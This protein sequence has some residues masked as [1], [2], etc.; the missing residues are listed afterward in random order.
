MYR[1][2]FLNGKFKGKRLTI[3]QGSVLIGRDHDCQIDLDDDDEVSRHHA[4][5]E[6]RAGGIVIRDLGATNRLEVNQQPVKEHRLRHGDRIEVGRTMLEFQLPNAGAAP[7][8]R[9]RFSKMQATSIAAITLVILIQVLF[10]VLFPLWQRREAKPVILPDPVLAEATTATEFTGPPPPPPAPSP[11]ELVG[12]LPA[13]ESA[14]SASPGAPQPEPEPVEESAP[15]P[16]VEPEP[17][18]PV[19]AL[20]TEV[21]GL[22]RRIED[23]LAG[24]QGPAPAPEPA[25]PSGPPAMPVDPLLA[26]AR[27][28][29]ADAQR[30]IAATNF[31]GADNILERVTMLAPDFVP[32]LRERALLFEKRGML[33]QAGEQWQAIMRL[34]SGT[35]YYAKAA[36]ERQR[37]AQLEAAKNNINTPIRARESSSSAPAMERRIRIVSVDRERFQANNEFDEMRLVRITLRPRN[38]EGAV[39]SDQVQVVVTFFD[40]V[41]GSERL[42]RTRALVPEEPIRLEGPW[43]AGE[44]RNITAAYMLKNGFRDEEFRLLGEK[45]VYEGHV[46]AVYYRGVLQD[47]S[48]LPQRLLVIEPP[49]RALAR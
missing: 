16:S 39:A 19:S 48:A 40:R 27:E 8:Q 25:V 20:R 4:V 44:S 26:K 14:S 22:R 15:A 12:P 35:P 42:V 2:L 47:A 18:S 13:T 5:I 3:Q 23:Q 37:I 6:Y 24:E 9:R 30:E 21:E 49:P 28:M 11:S 34:S 33:K 10:V 38:N 7:R 45:R 36:E 1:L 29:L 31:I 17:Q 32:A 43:S 41:D 46:V